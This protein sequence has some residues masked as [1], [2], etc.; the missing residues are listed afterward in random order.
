MSEEQDSTFK[1]SKLANTGRDGKRVQ[2]RYSDEDRYIAL[3][4]VDLNGGNVY[5]RVFVKSC[6]WQTLGGDPVSVYLYSVFEVHAL[7]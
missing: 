7:S 1:P 5:R 4:A 2:R 6:V 3:A